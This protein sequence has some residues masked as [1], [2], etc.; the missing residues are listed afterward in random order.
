MK[1][2]NLFLFFIGRNSPCIEPKEVKSM[3][4][5]K[6][7]SNLLKTFNYSNIS[8]KANG[9]ISDYTKNVTSKNKGF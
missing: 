9:Q 2:I 8:N 4:R 6:G 5:L 3:I 7:F 1:S